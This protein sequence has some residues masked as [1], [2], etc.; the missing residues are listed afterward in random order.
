[1]E[2]LRATTI[3]FATHLRRIAFS[4]RTLTCL[5]LCLVPVLAAAMVVRVVE[6]H[7]ES[8]PALEIGWGLVVMVIVPIVSLVIGS[9][10]VAEEVDDRTITYL[11]T[12]PIPR[13]AVL[14]GRWAASLVVIVVLLLSSSEL[15]FLILDRGAA[16]NQEMVLPAGMLGGLRM[17]IVIGAVIYSA[18]FTAIGTLIKHPMVVG[19]GYT[20]VYEDFISSLPNESQSITVQYYLKSWLAGQSEEI[21]HR[22]RHIALEDPVSSGEALGTLAIVLAIALAVGCWTVSR[23]QYVLSS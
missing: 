2:L 8:T 21:A 10:V 11:F 4:K 15:V 1:M 7:G 20:F 22:M 18:L 13:M 14:L 3:L 19:L 5:A 12:R 6:M 17:V 9:A 16:T 23:K